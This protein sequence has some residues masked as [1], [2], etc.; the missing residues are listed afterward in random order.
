MLP[1]ELVIGALLLVIDLAFLGANLLKI[2]EGGWVPLAVGAVVFVLL[3]TWQK[4]RTLLVG[5]VLAECVPLT[6][7]LKDAEKQQCARVPGT[8]IFLTAYRDM[9]PT[10]LILNLKHNKVLHERNVLLTVVNEDIPRVPAKDRVTIELVSKGFYRILAHYG[11]MQDPD[12]PRLLRQCKT[13]GLEFDLAETT[14]FL[15][16]ETLVPAPS[17]PMSRWREQVFIFMFRNAMNATDFFRI[18][19]NR[20]VEFRALVQF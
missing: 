10:A 4:G 18:P 1:P 12:I 13:L 11:F 7:F 2:P 3:T 19:S 20:V 8:A 9:A 6:E 16:R 14:F 15:G 5:R 17:P